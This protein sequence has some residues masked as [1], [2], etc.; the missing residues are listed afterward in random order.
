MKFCAW[1]RFPVNP[2]GKRWQIC[3]KRSKIIACLDEV[4][5]RLLDGYWSPNPPVSITVLPEGERPDG[6]TSLD[7]VD[8]TDEDLEHLLAVELVGAHA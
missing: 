1:G 6:P 4:K 7:L 8:W 5:L 2:P 3:S